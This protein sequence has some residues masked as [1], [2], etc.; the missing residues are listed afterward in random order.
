[1]PKPKLVQTEPT[2]NG[3]THTTNAR[4]RRPTTL[5]KEGKGP[6]AVGAQTARGWGIRAT[7]GR[8]IASMKELQSASWST[9]A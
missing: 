2:T 4:G 5:T 8:A 1:M 7:L 9:G 6:P 3:E